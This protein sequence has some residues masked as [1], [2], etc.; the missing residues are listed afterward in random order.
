MHTIHT[1]EAA[2]P[3]KDTQ[4]SRSGDENTAHCPIQHV[5]DAGNHGCN[6]ISCMHVCRICNWGLA[7]MQLSRIATESCDQNSNGLFQQLWDSELKAVMGSYE[8][9]WA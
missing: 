9:L 7:G 5:G 2:K 1:G 4:S 8:D 6:P 3:D